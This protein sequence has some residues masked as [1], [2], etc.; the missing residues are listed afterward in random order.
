MTRAVCHTVLSFPLFSMT[1]DRKY[2]D[3]L[4]GWDKDSEIA[5][6]LLAWAKQFR[7]G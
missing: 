1:W 5:H 4:V 3:E 6:Q 7:F 2:N